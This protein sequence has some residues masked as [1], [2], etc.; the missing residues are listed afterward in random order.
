MKVAI[1]GGGPLGMEAA[2]YGARAGFEVQVYERGRLAENVRQWGHVR[3]FTEWARNRSPLAERLL[4]ERGDTL[5]APQSTSTGNE[6][7]DYVLRVASLPELRGRI[8]PQTEVIS[9][10][11]E[12]LLK[13]DLI[14]DVRRTERPFRLLLKTAAGE[15]IRHADA[16]IDAS[17]VYATPNYLGN[18]GMRC[19]GEREHGA[20]IDYHLP[21]V[22]GRDRVRFAN[23]HTLVVG[24]GH[25]AASTLRSIGD[26]FT[27]FPQTRITWVVRR[28][29]PMHG[30]PYSLIPDDPSPHRNDLHLRANELSTHPQVTFCPRS[31]VEA[32][33]RAG[34]GFRVA[35]NPGADAFH[36]IEACDNI[37]AHTGFRP[38][39]TLWQE[40][41]VDVH[42]ATDGPRRLAQSLI[43]HN[44]RSGVGLSTGYAEKTPSMADDANST[45]VLHAETVGG[46]STLRQDQTSESGDVGGDEAVADRWRFQPDDP[47][48]LWSGEP[49]FFIVGIKSYGRDAGFLMQNGFRQVRNVYRLLS[50]EAKLDLYEGELN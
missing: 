41:A 50:A 33:E 39:H 27:E 22:T 49:N 28:D 32:I 37:V 42:P 46:E 25:S 3:V 34:R 17:G 11:R 7:A 19:P 2:L 38:D 9:L 13:S 20:R 44:H 16:V 8:S 1:I 23:R 47:A 31:T 12:R 36:F 26:L 30:F 35:L 18:G 43:F 5:P 48:L 15:A 21:D 40:L 45:G 29:V 4:Q 24:S 10:S 6:L 14:D